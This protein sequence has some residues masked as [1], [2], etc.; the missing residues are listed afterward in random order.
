M[1]WVDKV[2]CI[3]CG[4]CVNVCPV[5]AIALVDMVADINMSECIRC[6]ACH[7]SCPQGAVK[8]DSEKMQDEIEANV[9]K[10]KSDM[11]HYKSEE[12]RQSCLGRNIK[13][14]RLKIKIAEKTMELLEEMKTK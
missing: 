7:H 10:V 2:E 5:E 9:E 3:G 8:H 14:F 12:E 11:K 13:H 1:P 4:I 6:G